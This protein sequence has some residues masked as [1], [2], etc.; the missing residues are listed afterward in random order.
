MAAK[1]LTLSFAAASLALTLAMPAVQAQTMIGSGNVQINPQALDQLGGFTG[2][3][4]NG[5]GYNGGQAPLLGATGRLPQAQQ[6]AGPAPLLGETG[7]ARSTSSAK[8]R[9]ARVARP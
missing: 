3:R 7:R 9:P 1:P 2:P 6:A 8:P 5:T 4:L